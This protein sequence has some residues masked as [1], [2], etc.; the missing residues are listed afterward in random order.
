M[1]MTEHGWFDLLVSCQVKPI[2][3]GSWAQVFAKV[4]DD[5]TFSAGASEIDDFLG[6]VLHE[7]DGLSRVEEGLNYNAERLTV[8]WP[9]RFPTLADAQPYARNPQSLA[10]KVYGGRM[11]N[12]EPGDGYKYRGR[13]IIQITGKGNYQLVSD[14][15]GIDLVAEPEKMAEPETAL[16]AAIAWWEDKIPDSAMG[17]TLAITKRVNGGTLGLAHRQ[18]LTAKAAHEIQEVGSNDVA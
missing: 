3:A 7:S 6:Q 11:G 15:L 2:V 17:D 10:N 4:V 9:K 16:R 13:G 8:V 14:V 5:S 1:Q 18:E 12:T